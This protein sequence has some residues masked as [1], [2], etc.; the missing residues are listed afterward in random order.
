M[1]GLMALPTSDRKQDSPT[2]APVRSKHAAHG[3]ISLIA[4]IPFERADLHTKDILGQVYEYYLRQFALAE[5]KKS[6]QYLTPRSLVPLI[7]EMLDP[8][9]KFTGLV[10]MQRMS[11]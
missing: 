5:G 9:Q 3:L 4:T 6:G 11:S 1:S 8:H 2:P 7:V 10:A